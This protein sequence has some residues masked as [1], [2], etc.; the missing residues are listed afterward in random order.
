M[1]D[2]QA[3]VQF[4]GEERPRASAADNLA[5]AAWNYLCDGEQSIDW[6]GLPLVAE[7]LGITDIEGLLGRLLV[8][9]SHKPSEG[10]PPDGTCNPVD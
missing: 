3:G 4:E 7:L 2:A 5:I 6:A 8:I 9:K 10:T 1:L